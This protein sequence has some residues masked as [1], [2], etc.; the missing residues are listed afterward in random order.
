MELFIAFIIVLII[1]AAYFVHFIDRFGVR[2]W[3]YH[4]LPPA[5]CVE[6]PDRETQLIT[7]PYLP[8]V[9]RRQSLI[10]EYDHEVMV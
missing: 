9:R 5:L 6:Y 1:A 7:N 8:I 2:H 4:S 3:A 10:Q